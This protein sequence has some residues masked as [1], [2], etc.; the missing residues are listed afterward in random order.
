M[1]NSH[2][3]ALLAKH[4]NLDAKIATERSRPRPD[5]ILVAM[6]KKQ[7]LRIKE[8]LQRG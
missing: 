2:S 1:T 8:L 3:A 6:L 5:E 4:A 7:K